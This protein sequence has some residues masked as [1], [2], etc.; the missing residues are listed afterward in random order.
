MQEVL[1]QSLLA[2]TFGHAIYKSAGGL[3][4]AVSYDHCGASA[5]LNATETDLESNAQ[6]LPAHAQQEVCLQLVTHTTN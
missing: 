2:A 6:S 4:R 5:P 1:I 3:S